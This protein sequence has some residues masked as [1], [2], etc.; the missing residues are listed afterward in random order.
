[1]I[2]MYYLSRTKTIYVMITFVLYFIASFS[3]F[4]YKLNVKFMK[5]AI[6]FRY[7]Q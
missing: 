2:K 7:D 3:V 6:C 4:E 5:K 1:M